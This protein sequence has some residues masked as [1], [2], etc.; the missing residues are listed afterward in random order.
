MDP[1]VLLVGSRRRKPLTYNHLLYFMEKKKKRGKTKSTDSKAVNMDNNAQAWALSILPI[2]ISEMLW[3]SDAFVSPIFPLKKQEC[4]QKLPC[5]WPPT[6][7]WEV[8]QMGEQRQV[9]M[10]ELKKLCWRSDLQGS[11]PTPG[12]ALDDVVLDFKMIPS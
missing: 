10:S 8:G 9:E 1:T 11:P 12:P 7:F 5:A 6:V 2:W 4:L 3:A